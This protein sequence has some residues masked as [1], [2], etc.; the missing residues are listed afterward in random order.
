MSFPSIRLAVASAALALAG[1]ASLTGER[2]PADV[3]FV[4][5]GE[6]GAATARLITAAAHCPPLS[7]DGQ[8]V[9]MRVRVPTSSIPARAGQPHTP[10]SSAMLTCEASVPAGSTSASVAGQRLPVPQAAPRRIVVIGDT[11][12]RLKGKE[13][14]RTATTRRLPVRARGGQRRRLQAGPGDPR[15]RLPLPRK[16]CPADKPGCA[17]SPYGYG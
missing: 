1:C 13:R 12:C 8:A 17:G 16:P 7:V 2:G 10:P 5:I 9:P 15:R 3:A 14:T 11:G 6:N 4:V